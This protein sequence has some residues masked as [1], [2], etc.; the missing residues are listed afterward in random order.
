MPG[1]GEE[2]SRAAGIEARELRGRGARARAQ[3]AKL[4]SSHWHGRDDELE[5]FAAVTIVA[6][7]RAD[8]S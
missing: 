7:G 2:P 1:G 3:P 4:K 8:F 6:G 5:G